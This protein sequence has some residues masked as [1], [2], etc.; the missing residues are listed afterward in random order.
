MSQ[1]R[2]AIRIAA[3]ALAG[4]AAMLVSGCA[5]RDS[6]TVGS[7]PDDYRTN[8][9]IVIGEKDRVLDLPVGA[10]D[11]GMT[12]M[13]RVALRGFFANYDRSAAPLVT[14]MVPYGAPNSVAAGDAGR[15]FARYV[16][17]MGVKDSRVIVS[18]YQPSAPDVSAPIRVTYAAMRAYTDRCG[19]WPADLAD[20][21][22]NKHYANFGCSFQNNLAAQV[23]NPADLLGPRQPSEIDAERRETVIDGYRN[24]PFYTPVPRREVDY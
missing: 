23:A 20:T 15:D 7:I 11:R 12:E 21:A 22:D 10:G 13:H 16:Q 17:R 5:Q 14:I 19:R 4:L 18:S 9:P 6:I 2:F 3:P 24:A 8:H 1:A